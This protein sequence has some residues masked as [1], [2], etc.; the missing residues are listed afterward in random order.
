MFEQF[1][2]QA[3][4]ARR[5][6]AIMFTDIVGYTRMMGNDEQKALSLI[7]KNRTLH[8]KLIKKY[9]GKWL[10]EMGDGTLASFKTSSDA[11]Y[12]A[13]ELLRACE[14]ED[15]TLRIGIHQCEVT[16]EDGDIFGD[17]VNLASRIETL[18][19]PGQILVSGPVH[20]NV[21]NKPGISSAFLKETELKNIDELVKIY[22]VE[23]LK[24]SQNQWHKNPQAEESDILE[25]SIAVLPFVNM[26][27]DPEQE[28]FCDGISEEIINTIVQYPHLKV[29][30]RTSSFS[31]KGKNEDLRMIGQALGVSKVLEG[32]IRKMGNRIRITA[33]LVETSNGFHIWSK[34]YD[35]QLD[36]VFA[37]QDEIALEIGNQLNLTLSSGFDK[38]SIRKQ[39]QNIEAY[40]LY[41]KGRI[42]FYERGPTMFEALECFQ[43]ALKIDA[44]Y[45]LASAGLADTYVMLILHGYLPAEENWLFALRAVDVAVKNGPELAETYNSLAIISLFYEWNWDKAEIQFKKAIAINPSFIQAYVWYGYFHQIFVKNDI[46]SGIEQIKRAIK[47]DPLSTYARSCLCNAYALKDLYEEAIREGEHILEIDPKSILGNINI[48]ATLFWTGNYEKAIY[49]L[50]YSTKKSG[51]V[52]LYSLALLYLKAKQK[53]KAQEIYVKMEKQYNEKGL[54]PTALAIV[55]A[56]FGD[57]DKAIKLLRKACEIKDPSLIIYAVVHKDG[58]VLRSLPRYEKIIEKMGLKEVYKNR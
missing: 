22:S 20:R 29:S 12:C 57:K 11:V 21:K 19:K 53:D 41:L 31:F 39:T 6:A 45:A 18:A 51:I 16:E 38:H 9:G 50:E 3:S 7:R 5:L 8:Q 2:Q 17:G 14:Y 23:V 32:S 30:G 40:E 49:C 36:D 42:L 1:H 47:I 24:Q 48:G 35:R 43:N 56:A 15:I 46:N 4:S 27:N 28:F 34:K 55:A 58:Q 52:W 25:H 13:A 54:I 37:I 10:K 33:Q 44:E 26:S